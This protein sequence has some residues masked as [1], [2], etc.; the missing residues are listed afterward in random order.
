[1]PQTEEITSA[2]AEPESSLEASS[3]QRVALSIVVPVMNEEQN[4]RPLRH[5]VAHDF[6]DGPSLVADR[7]D[8]CREVV[9]AVDED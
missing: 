2:L 7:R 1:M 3:S 6:R 8:E 5:V 4:V 9:N